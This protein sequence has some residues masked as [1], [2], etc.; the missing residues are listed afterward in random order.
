MFSWWKHV[1]T[2]RFKS[3]ENSHPKRGTLNVI[4]YFRLG[5]SSLNLLPSS[6]LGAFPHINSELFPALPSPW[7]QATLNASRSRFQLSDL[8]DPHGSRWPD[9]GQKSGW[10]GWAGLRCPD[11]LRKKHDIWKRHFSMISEIS[12]FRFFGLISFRSR[13]HFEEISGEEWNVPNDMNSNPEECWG[14]WNLLRPP[15]GESNSSL[16]PAT[17]RKDCSHQITTR[18]CCGQNL[19]PLLISSKYLGFVDAYQFIPANMEWIYRN[20][21]L[22]RLIGFHQSPK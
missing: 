20:I 6:K 22:T 10:V 19:V 13:S 7:S 21:S 9:V 3:R 16:R 18:S 14:R 11:F 17:P 1:K 2:P 15:D 4:I 12:L 8:H 5:F